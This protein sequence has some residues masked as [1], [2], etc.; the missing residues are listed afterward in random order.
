MFDSDPSI[1][2]FERINPFS[3]S[4]SELK[5]FSFEDFYK[6]KIVVTGIVLDSYMNT[7]LREWF[8]KNPDLVLRSW[9]FSNK[10]KWDGEREVE[11]F[12][13]TAFFTWEYSNQIDACYLTPNYKIHEVLTLDQ[14][15]STPTMAELLFGLLKK[16][17][18]YI[19][20]IK[21]V[22][23]ILDDVNYLKIMHPK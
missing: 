3:L 19:K 23:G 2:T 4:S 5:N 21:L 8:D 6:S 7:L 18:Q 14:I 20:E 13:A 15:N 1:I 12:R 9:K 17:P 16:Y 11:Y 10:S 22:T